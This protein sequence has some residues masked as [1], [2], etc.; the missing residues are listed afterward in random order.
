MGF[1]SGHLSS[2][3]CC[4]IGWVQ[5]SKS[6][7]TEQ[8]DLGA[9]AQQSMSCLLHLIGE[10]KKLDSSRIRNGVKRKFNGTL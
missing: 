9:K 2:P 8:Q 7:R 10:C 5:L 4:L 6:V 1:P 3:P